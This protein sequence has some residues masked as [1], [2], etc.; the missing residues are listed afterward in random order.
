MPDKP[1]PE[2]ELYW[3]ERWQNAKLALEVARAHVQALKENVLPSDRYGSDS[4]N[5]YKSAL[6]QETAALIEY[7]RVLRIYTDL[8]VHGKLPDDNDERK[9]RARE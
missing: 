6:E 8:V 2:L 9:A 3:K 5:A 7:S 1:Q 4:A